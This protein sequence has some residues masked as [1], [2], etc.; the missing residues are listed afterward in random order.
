VIEGT[1]LP[2]DHMTG[3]VAI[4]KIGL[5]HSFYYSKEGRWIEDTNIKDGCSSTFCPV[6]GFEKFSLEREGNNSLRWRK[7]KYARSTKY[8]KS[9]INPGPSTS[10]KGTPL[11]LEN[12]VF[13]EVL[14]SLES[15]FPINS[16]PIQ[17]L[18]PLLEKLA[19]RRSAVSSGILYS[20]S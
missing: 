13:K 15:K 16:E 20:E 12:V 5:A 10:E 7:K 18:K 3:D 11:C 17:N 9:T 14:I 19:N 2:T 6:K 4:C 1:D 8:V